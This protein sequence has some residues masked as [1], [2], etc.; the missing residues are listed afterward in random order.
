MAKKSLAQKFKKQ[1]KKEPVKVEVSPEEEKLL[2]DLQSSLDML[3]QQFKH[4][5][6]ELNPNDIELKWE[7]L[8]SSK[9]TY[10]L[11]NKF[12]DKDYEINLENLD[13]LLPDIVNIQK[14]LAIIYKQTSGNHLLSKFR[15][16]IMK[17]SDFLSKIIS[18]LIQF[19]RF[20][21]LEQETITLNA[22]NVL[23]SG[24]DL[25]EI[26]TDLS[27]QT[28][29]N[30]LNIYYNTKIA[31]YFNDL[32]FNNKNIFVI[33]NPFDID[34][35]D[36]ESVKYPNP[37]DYID[38]Q[39]KER[40]DIPTSILDVFD[41]FMILRK[42]IRKLK[43]IK[44]ELDFDDMKYKQ[45]GK[46][47]QN[48]WNVKINEI[49]NEIEM[50]E[51]KF[52][53]IF[54]KPIFNL[55]KFKK[56]TD[57]NVF[58]NPYYLENNQAVYVYNVVDDFIYYF[59]NKYNTSNANLF[60]HVINIIFKTI[61]TSMSFDT[62]KEYIDYIEKPYELFYMRYIQSFVLF[63]EKHKNITKTQSQIDFNDFINYLINSITRIKEY[64]E[65]IEKNPSQLY[66]SFIEKYKKRDDLLQKKII[67]IKSNKFINELNC[68]ILLPQQSLNKID[69]C[70]KDV[71]KNTK[72]TI[73]FDLKNEIAQTD[74]QKFVKEI[75]LDYGKLVEKIDK[76]YYK[77]LYENFELF[78]LTF[79]NFDILFDKIYPKFVPSEY[80]NPIEQFDLWKNSTIDFGN[81]LS[82]YTDFI[83]T[84]IS[85]E[86][87]LIVIK[88]T[89][90]DIT[91]QVDLSIQ[92]KNKQ[93]IQAKEVLDETF[94]K[95]TESHERKAFIINIIA[96]LDKQLTIDE[97]NEH[98]N[99]LELL[100][101]KLPTDVDK[102]Q[103][104]NIIALIN[105]K[106]ALNNYDDKTLE[107]IIEEKKVDDSLEM[108]VNK[109]VVDSSICEHNKLFDQLIELQNM[110]NTFEENKLDSTMIELDIENIE[111]KI[112]N[113]KNKSDEK[114]S[115][116]Y[117]GIVLDTLQFAEIGTMEDLENVTT[118]KQRLMTLTNVERQQLDVENNIELMLN[119]LNK[120]I[121]MMDIVVAT[122]ELSK[123]KRPNNTIDNS[124]K[125]IIIDNLKLI[126]SKPSFSRNIY[127]NAKDLF[128]PNIIINMPLNNIKY[129]IVYDTL[130]MLTV[131]F[132]YQNSNLDEKHLKKCVGIE[133]FYNII[134]CIYNSLEKVEY[135]SKN[136]VYQEIILLNYSAHIYNLASDLYN[137]LPFDKKIPRSDIIQVEIEID[138][139]EN[140][141][142]KLDKE[143]LIINAKNIGLQTKNLS[144]D[145]L[146]KIIKQSTEKRRETIT[147]E[148]VDLTDNIKKKMY[149]VYTYHYNR[150]IDNLDIIYPNNKRT[151]YQYAELLDNPPKVGS[152]KINPTDD[153]WGF[154]NLYQY[155]FY[156]TL[157]EN[158]KNSKM[159]DYNNSHHDSEMKCIKD[160]NH[161]ISL[162]G[163]KI[164]LTRLVD[165]FYDR[166]RILKELKNNLDLFKTFFD[167]YKLKKNLKK[168]NK[169]KKKSIINTIVSNDKNNIM[170]MIGN[171]F[172]L[173]EEKQIQQ[174]NKLSKFGSITNIF[175]NSAIL[176]HYK[177][178]L[179]I[180]INNQY[181]I[182]NQLL[183]DEFK[184]YEI[185]ENFLDSNKQFVNVC[186]ICDTTSSILMNVSL[187]SMK[188]HD[189]HLQ[190]NV[191]TIIPYSTNDYM[192]WQSK[193]NSK[194]PDIDKKIIC[195]YCT[196]K[197]N[198]SD[199]I[200]KHIKSI[201]LKLEENKQSFNDA[202]QYKFIQNY[203]NNYVSYE[204]TK[205]KQLIEVEINDKEKRNKLRDIN[206][207]DAKN[208]NDLLDMSYIYTKYCDQH[209]LELGLATHYFVNKKCVYCNR[210]FINLR[211]DALN[212][213]NN[214][215]FDFIKK[216]EIYLDK[217][218]KNY[219][220]FSKPERIHQDKLDNNC[221]YPN[222][223]LK[224]F[225]EKKN[226]D[227]INNFISVNERWRLLKQTNNLNSII[228]D[229]IMDK[230]NNYYKFFKPLYIKSVGITDPYETLPISN[231]DKLSE[232]Y[233]SNKDIKEIFILKQYSENYYKEWLVKFP[234][235]K[236]DMVID[237]N[238]NAIHKDT[239]KLMNEC[240]KGNKKLEEC[241]KQIIDNENN[242]K[243]N[244]IKN[245][246]KYLMLNVVDQKESNL[247]VNKNNTNKNIAKFVDKLTSNVEHNIKETKEIY[248]NIVKNLE[249]YEKT[250]Y[251]QS[252]HIMLKNILP[253][254][255][256]PLVMLNNGHR[257]VF[258]R[259]VNV[260]ANFTD[261]PI[262]TK[263]KMIILDKNMNIDK[264]KDDCLLFFSK[265]KDN[266]AKYLSNF[267]DL[268]NLKISYSGYDFSS[269]E[270][271]FQFAKYVSS[272]S[273]KESLEQ[274]ANTIEKLPTGEKAKS[275]GSKSNMTKLGV[276]LNTQKWNK[277]RDDT[278]YDLIFQRMSKD[279]TFY[280]IISKYKGNVC[281]FE[282]G[283]EKAYWGGFFDKKTGIWKGQNK[284]GKIIKEVWTKFQ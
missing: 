130:F 64:I 118:E 229:A 31:I 200:L 279:K 117:C 218:M 7:K 268:P 168:L 110:R 163:A 169:D 204:L 242:I 76:I 182:I 258:Y 141:L 263:K 111:I 88:K 136:K 151:Y 220:I 238:I 47:P 108:E 93:V 243:I 70:I 22:I 129:Q 62:E 185:I 120:N 155:L 184:L 240:E 264:I 261:K 23:A 86:R 208:I 216:F 170:V 255:L 173:L 115:C 190:G 124:I 180:F 91:F 15:Q 247:V 8:I 13:L 112:E 54:Y 45:I 68:R 178:V 189:V 135:F 26:Q 94:H 100:I 119:I 262:S 174:L 166:Y 251:L 160:I 197:N 233:Y 172:V 153:D 246:Y 3:I 27:G 56:L 196:Y 35:K 217:L 127:R 175:N 50:V 157:D 49:D 30:T 278:M 132:L 237:D 191:K 207:N 60:E 48:D 253:T 209:I 29:L 145:D 195:P 223:E 188:Q 221:L 82:K 249:D 121:R 269:V 85:F 206:H 152:I 113:C 254:V 275:F 41:F 158:H 25:N 21:Q 147:S 232:N 65:Q 156:N 179:N 24:F 283:G 148:I 235:I 146:I 193:I 33:D 72:K 134:Q 87:Q 9:L 199:K 210:T 201:H 55:L 125:N 187:H 42:N 161:L 225:K 83:K 46:W 37:I 228:I 138:K 104:Y 59:I 36:I 142:N 96:E 226:K 274:I 266:D 256:R 143:Q 58:N 282:R 11:G 92:F 245:A 90:N 38:K 244:I 205:D 81:L 236:P 16:K 122:Q 4:D 40:P 250:K 1:I 73:L 57:L 6:T 66:I 176:K 257:N 150:L 260:L 164:L 51:I 39:D 2:E 144:K 32:L 270:K 52:F 131:I 203:N 167:I 231:I 14:L 97:L 79:S 139:F 61:S 67:R 241:N 12:D 133:S 63:I 43:N 224:D 284:L 202:N 272:N 267:Q 109:I 140:I 194:T 162:N 28:L 215:V 183:N 281:H 198:S 75:L 214:N 53:K 277:S 280:D 98:K 248:T 71:N 126:I 149:D 80:L 18:K 186:A 212:F 259:G 171:T 103:Y 137:E 154:I 123:F 213:G 128:H 114:I 276:S 95:A 165:R 105:K 101:A 20:T 106:I 44:T 78:V 17:W 271:A 230:I 273:N 77:D 89:D 211:K 159:N 5:L 219:C 99:K 107:E 116:K 265:S 227:I 222:F 102:K 181:N 234:H 84:L 252:R 10:L 34:K 19:R 177:N 192:I 69:E 74:I 239:I